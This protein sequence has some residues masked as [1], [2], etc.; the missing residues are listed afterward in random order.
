M[1]KYYDG[2]MGKRVQRTLGIG[3]LLF[4]LTGMEQENG[5]CRRSREGVCPP[6]PHPCGHL[7][8]ARITHEKR[9]KIP[10]FFQKQKMLEQYVAGRNFL[11]A[12]Q[13]AYELKKY[14]LAMEY[15]EQGGFFAQAGQL[16]EFLGKKT[17]AIDYYKRAEGCEGAVVELAL[18]VVCESKEKLKGLRDANTC[19]G[20][21]AGCVCRLEEQQVYEQVIEYYELA[22]DFSKDHVYYLDA[23]RLARQRKDFVAAIRNYQKSGTIRFVYAE[24]KKE[25]EGELS[26]LIE[27][28]KFS[29]AGD[30]A[31][32]L[33]KYGLVHALSIAADEAKEYLRM[34]R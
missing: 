20:V 32:S 12:A 21:H 5:G 15:Y 2:G 19:S 24:L 31:S 7:F 6:I 14:V 23:A 30:L 22:G 1:G 17:K 3:V 4:C 8:Q 34:K 29:K 16:A 9:E 18:E 10:V 27:E 11:G 13:I 25:A 33:D 28:G 26:V